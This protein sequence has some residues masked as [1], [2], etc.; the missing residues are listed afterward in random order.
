[1]IEKE[2]AK[3]AASQA[4]GEHGEDHQDARRP[5]RPPARPPPRPIAR[6]ERGLDRRRRHPAGVDL[7]ARIQQ[8]AYELWERDGRPEGRDHA[9]WQQAEREIGARRGSADAARRS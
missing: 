5:G 4:A 9:H 2:P 3:T 8:R 6:Q 7:Q 1:M